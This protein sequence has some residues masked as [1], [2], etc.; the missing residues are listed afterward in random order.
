[1]TDT[2]KPL[3]TSAFA[4]RP[5]TAS[6]F[7]RVIF[8]F[9]APL[10]VLVVLFNF[11]RAYVHAD[12]GSCADIVCTLTKRYGDAFAV[13]SS[14]TKETLKRGASVNI[15]LARELLFFNVTFAFTTALVAILAFALAFP[16]LDLVGPIRYPAA[17]LVIPPAIAILAF[18]LYAIGWDTDWPRPNSYR[19]KMG[20]LIFD[21]WAG[22]FVYNGRCLALSVFGMFFVFHLFNVAAYLYRRLTG[23]GD[24]R[25]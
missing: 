14:F 24:H 21:Y 13:V 6:R 16:K 5:L 3:V 8:W 19:G 15:A 1:L 2:S 7:F 17:I 12:S 18:M 11:W 9:N 10:I 20:R 25:I 22:A 4:V 23:R